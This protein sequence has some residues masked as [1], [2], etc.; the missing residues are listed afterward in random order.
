M[1]LSE[2]AAQVEE[3]QRTGLDLEIESDFSIESL[4]GIKL[5]IDRIKAALRLSE[6]HLTL[7]MKDAV[8]PDGEFIEGIGYVK[9]G[10]RVAY[11]FADVMAL[12]D[13]HYVS[14]G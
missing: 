5:A 14:T 1:K 12:E 13:E 9:I 2:L 3:Y 10:S 8:P 11:R 6:D 4:A 7:V